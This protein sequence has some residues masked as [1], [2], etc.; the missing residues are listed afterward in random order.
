[1]TGRAFVTGGTGVVGRPILSR[2]LGEGRPVAALVRSEESARAVSAQGAEAVPGD[3]FDLEALAGGM[4]GCETVFHA[5]GLN[6]FCLPDPQSLF[7]V[8]V[9]GSRAVV[10][11][12]AGTGVRRVVYTSSA[13]TLGEER[14]SVGREDTRHRGWFLSAYERSKYEAERAVLA[15][16]ERRGIDLVCVNPSSVQGPGRT[17]GTA[18][19]LLDYLNGRLKAIV[20]T[21][22]SFVDVADAAEGHLLAE[23]NGQSG[24]RYVLN[25]ATLAV[26]E[27]LD[28]LAR[29]TGVRLPVRRLPGGAAMA[30]AGVVEA[31]FRLRGRRPPLCREMV[32]TLLHGH[33]YDGSKAAKELGLRYTSAED[34]LRRTVAWYV[35]Q[36]LIGRPLPRLR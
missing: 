11:A 23:A 2:L 22:L 28:L 29:I 19:L 35:D 27:V 31:A 32:R 36:G 10:A 8:N 9:Q 18:K 5:A 15:E 33:A 34:C 20:E 3:L 12:A 25:G 4:R 21:R 17:G 14:G 7:R 26:G 30:L 13:A 24:Q 6:A 1:V 16:A